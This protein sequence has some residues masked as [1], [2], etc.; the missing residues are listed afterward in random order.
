MTMPGVRL[1]DLAADLAIGISFCTRLPLV[2]S[3]PVAGADIARAS[4]TFPLAGVAVGLAGAA[5]Y[6]LARKAGLPP[7]PGAALALTA[8]LLATGCLHEDGLVDTADGFGGGA[9]RERRLEIMRDSRIGTYGACALAMSLLLRWGALASLAEPAAVMPALIASHAA[10]RATMPLFM[11]LVPRARND[12]LSADVGLPPRESA[13]AAIVIAIIAL[14]FFLDA[15][16]AF[17]AMLLLV[18]AAAAIAW[19]CLKLIGG[20]TGDVLGAMEQT[21]EIVVLLVAAAA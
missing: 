5:V 13:V 7:L 18:C 1:R 12:G 17:I 2:S 19:L 4:W 14:G 10:A 8:M 6:W 9:T 16:A 11:R 21:A 20:Q 3:G 15:T